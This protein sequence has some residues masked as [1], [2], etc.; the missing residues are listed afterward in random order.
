MYRYIWMDGCKHACTYIHVYVDTYVDTYVCML[1]AKQLYIF[2]MCLIYI[3]YIY[4]IIIVII[5]IYINNFQ[6]DS[7]FTGHLQ[8]AAGHLRHAEHRGAGAAQGEV[9]HHGGPSLSAPEEPSMTLRFFEPR[10]E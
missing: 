10:G 6:F 4:I 8:E 9:Q 2:A 5:Y 7:G 3:I 1:Q